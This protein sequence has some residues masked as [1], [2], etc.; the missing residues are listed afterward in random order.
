MY[1]L[2]ARAAVFT[3]AAFREVLCF[4]AGACF[5]GDVVDVFFEEGVHGDASSLVVVNIVDDG[6]GDCCFEVVFQHECV[7][8]CLD[9]VGVPDAV[10]GCFA[11]FEFNWDY[12]V[13][14]AFEFVDASFKAKSLALEAVF[15]FDFWCY[16]RPEFVSGESLVEKRSDSVC[17]VGC[18]ESG[19]RECLSEGV[20]WL[21]VYHFEGVEV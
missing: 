4:E 5:G 17:S 11:A 18:F 9:A 10:L 21:D 2:C 15:S 16:G 19:E 20:V 8:G 13:W 1:E 6:F 7:S 14:V 12:L 3:S